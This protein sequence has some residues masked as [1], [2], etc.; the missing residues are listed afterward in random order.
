MWTQQHV[1]D[2]EAPIVEDVAMA[3]AVDGDDAVVVS[4]HVTVT[5]QYF[6][7]WVVKYGADGPASI[8]AWTRCRLERAGVAGTGRHEESAVLALGLANA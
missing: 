7:A 1:S 8:T 5:G 4:G 3:V 2:A 6:D